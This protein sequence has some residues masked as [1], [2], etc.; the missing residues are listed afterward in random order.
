MAGAVMYDFNPRILPC[1]SLKY[2]FL[3]RFE[4]LTVVSMKMTA[5]WDIVPCSLVEVG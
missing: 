2:Y 1:Y 5:F 4:V 3:V